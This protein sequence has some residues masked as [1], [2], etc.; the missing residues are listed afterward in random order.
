MTKGS[1][2]YLVGHIS[3]FSFPQLSSHVKHLLINPN[4]SFAPS[5]PPVREAKLE[6]CMETKYSG[7]AVSSACAPWLRWVARGGSGFPFKPQ[8]ENMVPSKK[9]LPYDSRLISG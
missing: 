3:D 8:T 5:H 6:I 4:M 2:S 1:F 7:A 9:T